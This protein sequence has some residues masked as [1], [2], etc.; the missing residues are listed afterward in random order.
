M[1]LHFGSETNLGTE[2]LEARL[3]TSGRKVRGRKAARRKRRPRGG[4]GCE[5]RER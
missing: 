4:P 1:H 2:R 5:A 3:R